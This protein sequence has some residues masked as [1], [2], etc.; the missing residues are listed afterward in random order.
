MRRF[1]LL[2]V[3]ASCF[4]W[5][6]RCGFAG[7]FRLIVQGNNKLAI[8]G[9]DGSI[10][11][12]MP[13]GGIHDIHVL[14]NDHIMVQK[15]HAVVAE[16]DP[17]T[18]RVVWSYDASKRNGNQGKRVEVHAFQPLPNGS[19]MIAESGSGRIIEIDRAGNVEKEIFLK[20]DRPHPH[21]DTRL[22]RKLDS[23][24]YLVCH[25]QDGTVREYHGKTGEVVW[26]YQVP[27]FGKVGRKG[28]GPQAFGNQVFSAVRLTNDNTLITTGNGHSI[29]EVSPDKDIIWKLEQND[30]PGIT[31]AWVTTVEVLP[32]GNYVIGNCHAGAENPLLIEV[33]PKTKQVVW[34]FDQFD[35]FGNSVPN[36]QILGIHGKSIR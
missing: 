32:D 26:E 27:L 14:E 3:A 19:V 4:F 23:G 33:D 11:W 9:P 13:W 35:V 25:E 16:I 36:S 34:T 12:Q 15:G 6:A 8:V 2:I 31:L 18:K 22:A 10:E 7:P 21:H 29:L 20:L 1:L 24:H 30:L 5:I 17:A 28:H